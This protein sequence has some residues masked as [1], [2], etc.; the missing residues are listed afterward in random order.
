MS[1]KVIRFQSILMIDFYLRKNDL[2]AKMWNNSPNYY[3][4][5]N[6]K[7]RGYYS[8]RSRSW[9]SGT[10]IT[11]RRRLQKER[12]IRIKGPDVVKP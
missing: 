11:G 8:R 3:A 12:C 5:R 10:D 7:E 4:S 1:L 6:S 9:L 2:C